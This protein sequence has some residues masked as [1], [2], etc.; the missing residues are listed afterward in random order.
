M[1][2]RAL[3]FCQERSAPVG[4]EQF[5]SRQLPL[6]VINFRREWSVLVE[7]AVAGPIVFCSKLKAKQGSTTRIEVLTAVLS[8]G[9]GRV[10]MA[11]LAESDCRL[12]QRGHW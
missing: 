6:R 2:Q 7:V 10:T 3:G 11:R 1:R 12:T 4:N 8:I 5:K 9:S